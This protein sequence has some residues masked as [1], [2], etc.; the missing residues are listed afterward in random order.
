MHG[1][2]ITRAL[3]NPINRTNGKNCKPTKTQMAN[4][5]LKLF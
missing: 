1:W 2:T 4:Y 3:Y 5:I